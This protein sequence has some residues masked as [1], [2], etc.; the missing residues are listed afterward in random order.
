MTEVKYRGGVGFRG[1]NDF[2]KSLLS[3][4]RWR[5]M[6]KEGSLMEK[7]FKT[8]YYTRSTFMEAKLRFQPSY[9]WRRII[10]AKE[11]IQQGSF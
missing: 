6:S 11:L 3:K 5:L 7:I 10:C 9:A 1:F 4:H 8:K 2:N